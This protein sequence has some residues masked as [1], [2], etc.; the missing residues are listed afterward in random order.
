MKA[1]YYALD[2]SSSVL[3]FFKSA[4]SFFLDLQAQLD[5]IK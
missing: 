1:D 3:N 4:F 2:K 5:L